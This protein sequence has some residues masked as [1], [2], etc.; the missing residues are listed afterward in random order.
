LKKKWGKA[1]EVPELDA[2]GDI[3]KDPGWELTP[4]GERVLILGMSGKV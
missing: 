3:V 1:A 2:R 4:E